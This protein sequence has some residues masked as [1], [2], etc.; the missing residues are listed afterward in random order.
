MF[1]SVRFPLFFT[2]IEDYPFATNVGAVFLVKVG[3]T[4][5]AILPKHILKTFHLRDL[6]ITSS[7]T[8]FN[9]VGVEDAYQFNGY[10]EA[11]RAT[12]IEDILVAFFPEFVTPSDFET[13]FPFEFMDAAP[14]QDGDEVVT[15][16]FNRDNSILTKEEVRIHQVVVEAIVTPKKSADF[17]LR[18]CVGTFNLEP[19]GD[20]LKSVTGLSGS[21]VFNRRSGL[22]CG[23]T[24]RGGITENGEIILRFVESFDLIRII[25]AAVSGADFVEYEKINKELKGFTAYIRQ[26]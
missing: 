16:G 26:I 12:D 18:E 2:G 24:T 17:T 9:S 7:L 20:K 5:I 11:T 6:R 14:V 25:N 19:E 15:Y 21:P 10:K 13:I 8:V 22:C 1:H 23:L 3:K 4:P